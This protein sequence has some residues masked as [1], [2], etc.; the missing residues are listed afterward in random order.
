MRKEII[1]PE[2]VRWWIEKVSAQATIV[3]VQ[4]IFPGPQFQSAGGSGAN[5]KREK[6]SCNQLRSP[7]CV[8]LKQTCFR[9]SAVNLVTQW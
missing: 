7:T 5:F 3:R 1:D 2:R 9:F 8:V 6:H 4:L